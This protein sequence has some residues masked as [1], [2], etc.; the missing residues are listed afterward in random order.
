MER[1]LSVFWHSLLVVA[2]KCKRG[3]VVCSLKGRFHHLCP[4]C[5]CVRA[6]AGFASPARSHFTFHFISAP[7]CSLCVLGQLCVCLGRRVCCQSIAVVALDQLFTSTSVELQRTQSI[8]Q[9]L[10]IIRQPFSPFFLPFSSTPVCVCPS[11]PVLHKPQTT[12]KIEPNKNNEEQ[13]TAQ[14]FL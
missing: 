3:G 14:L 9:S 10:P 5:V 2:H 12:R 13:K 11:R 4:P 1:E 8:S 6:C 7:V